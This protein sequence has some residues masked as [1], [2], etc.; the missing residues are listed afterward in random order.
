V[1]IKLADNLRYDDEETFKAPNEIDDEY[2]SSGM[3]D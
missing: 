3:I 1:A 2:A